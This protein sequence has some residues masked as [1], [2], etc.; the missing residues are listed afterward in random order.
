MFL[1]PHKA[2]AMHWDTALSAFVVLAI[3]MLDAAVV[4]F[5]GVCFMDIA[6]DEV[7]L[8]W[9][10]VPCV[11]GLEHTPKCRDPQT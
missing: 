9:G 4:V 2:A 7:S 3:S 10:L 11:G 5:G 1:V 6:S 8:H